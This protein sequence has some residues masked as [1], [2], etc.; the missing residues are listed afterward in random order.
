MKID[1]HNLKNEVVGTVELPPSIF[2]VAWKPTLVQQVVLAQRA[3]ARDPWAHTKDRSDVRGGGRK[4]WK[5]KGTGQA[6]HGSR[7]SPIWRGGGVTHGPRN[8]RDYSQK[9]NK[10][11]KKV[12]LASVL[13]RK[14]HDHELMVVDSFV[15][16]SH[17]TKSLLASLRPLLEVAPRIKRINAL[18][19]HDAQNANLSRAGHNIPKTKVL[20][21][22]SLNVYD[23][24]AYKHLVLDAQAIPM[25][26]KHFSVK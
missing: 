5:Q 2:D 9:V 4:P 10:K 13:S 7:R 19:V 1:I 25:I 11:M 22:E 18:L 6:R 20:S 21:A 14:L 23:V 12:A 3:N 15:L 24:L 16:D 17:K 8:E 26:T